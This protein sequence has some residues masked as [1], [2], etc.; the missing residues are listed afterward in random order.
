MWADLRGVRRSQTREVRSLEMGKSAAGQP[1]EAPAMGLMCLLSLNPPYSGS[2]LQLSCAPHTL[3][4][5][6]L[7]VEQ[8]PVEK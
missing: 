4:T 2:A 8:N 7:G 1:S 5:C 3:L 6:Y